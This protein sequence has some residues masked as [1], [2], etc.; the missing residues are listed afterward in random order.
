MQYLYGEYSVD[1]K[2]FTDALDGHQ[3]NVAVVNVLYLN[4]VGVHDVKDLGTVEQL[5][6]WEPHRTYHTWNNTISKLSK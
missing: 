5:V 4:T 3:L 2:Q 1:V 6:S